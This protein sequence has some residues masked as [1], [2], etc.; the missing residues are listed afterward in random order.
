M[1]MIMSSL[2]ALWHRFTALV[3]PLRKLTVWRALG[4]LFTLV[5]FA[6][7]SIAPFLRSVPAS[8]NPV[9]Y[10]L[11]QWP[12]ITLLLL[13]AGWLKWKDAIVKH[14]KKG[15]SRIS[16]KYH[17]TLSSLIR[18]L[19]LKKLTNS[20]KI[21]MIRRNLL[22]CV[23]L[24]V[25]DYLETE[26]ENIDANL[27]AFCLDRN[28]MTCI[29]RSSLARKPL[30]DRIYELTDHY[31]PWLC[32]KENQ[33]RLVND[34]RNHPAWDDL[35]QPPYRSVL[36]IPLSVGDGFVGSLTIDS[37]EPYFFEGHALEIENLVQPLIS[38]ICLTF[39]S[40][41]DKKVIESS[42]PER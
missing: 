1:S 8:S 39:Q 25:A 17:A 23:V 13:C 33:S 26:I 18:N 6:F 7:V 15:R 3:S 11:S 38:L 20:S 28:H 4:G 22:E 16:K 30:S 19:E 12:L 9:S 36:Y 10:L 27:I 21:D 40:D 2:L 35:Q 14:M 37:P 29:A 5:A 24:A 41:G 42:P 31:Y 34:T 32:I